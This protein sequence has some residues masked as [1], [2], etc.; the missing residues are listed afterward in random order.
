VTCVVA[1]PGESIESLLKRFKKVVERSGILAEL[2][3]HEF[4][5]KPSV[6]KK[7]KKAAAKKR[8][9][10]KQKK[11]D[12]VPNKNTNNKN[13]KFNKDRTEKLPNPPAGDGK[14]YKNNPR[15]SSSNPDQYNKK[16][17][18][19]KLASERQPQKKQ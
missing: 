14:D 17:Y 1:K 6:R 8:L 9:L 12:R 13:F 5:E 11:F 10:K 18:D 2:K 15:K 4:Y 3:K 19:K 16:P 7:R